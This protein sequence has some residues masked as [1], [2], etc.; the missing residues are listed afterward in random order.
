MTAIRPMGTVQPPANFYLKRTGG[1][2]KKSPK[3]S[4][5]KAVII[6][7]DPDGQH[8]RWVRDVAATSSLSAGEEAFAVEKIQPYFSPYFREAHESKDKN[9]IEAQLRW[10]EAGEQTNLEALARMINDVIKRKAQG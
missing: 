5:P 8:A 1:N 2:R 10:A 3:N 4:P 6:E 7:I 9:T